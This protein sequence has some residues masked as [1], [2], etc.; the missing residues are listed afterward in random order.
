MKLSSNLLVISGIATAAAA[1]AAFVTNGSSKKK[2]HTTTLAM[3]RRSLIPSTRSLLKPSG[4]FQDVEEFFD[5]QLEEFDDFFEVPMR[6]ALPSRLFTKGA[7]TFKNMAISRE[8]NSS[9]NIED[10]DDKVI[11]TVDV[12]G[13][14]A[15]DIDVKIEHDGRVIRLSGTKKSKEGEVEIESRFEK[16]FMLGNNRFETDNFTANLVDGVLTITAP[17]RFEKE[18]KESKIKVTELAPEAISEPPV[19]K[20]EFEDKEPPA[21]NEETEEKAE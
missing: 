5:S 17:K 7:D 16:A 11:L 9:Y 21:S 10:A 6:M 2:P 20:E 3:R 13:M 14:K 15:D 4:F 18:I 8:R 12:P 19:S 1:D